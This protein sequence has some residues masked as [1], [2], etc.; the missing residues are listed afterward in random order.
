MAKAHEVKAALAVLERE[1]RYSADSLN[2]TQNCLLTELQKPATT[3]EQK[4]AKQ[5][6]CDKLS[7][8]LKL[9][10]LLLDKKVEAL[11]LA[12]K[13]V[14]IYCASFYFLS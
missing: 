7:S 6:T 13:E 3:P 10:N 12:T 9:Q 8:E 11:N 1:A 2:Q 4:V 5:K 14:I